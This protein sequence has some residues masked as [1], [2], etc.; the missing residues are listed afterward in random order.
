M[1]DDRIR[2]NLE[3]MGFT[4]IGNIVPYFYIT[5]IYDN[6][7]LKREVDD[8]EIISSEIRELI[9]N[10]ILEAIENELREDKHSKPEKWIKKI[11][12]EGLL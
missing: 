10:D 2:I 4:L 3:L 7:N 8:M 11:F 12:I 6:Q 5:G 1:L 9:K